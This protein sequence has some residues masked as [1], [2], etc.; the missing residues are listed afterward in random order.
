MYVIDSPS[1]FPLQFSDK[2]FSSMDEFPVTEVTESTKFLTVKVS[3]SN[4][5][6]G[7]EIQNPGGQPF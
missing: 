4:G 7:V 6:N 2:I 3:L 5:V 1:K